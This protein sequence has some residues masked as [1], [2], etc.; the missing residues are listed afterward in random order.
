M[1]KRTQRRSVPSGIAFLLVLLLALPAVAYKLPDTGQTQC[2]GV[3]GKIKPI[4]CPPPD[5]PL[6]QDGSYTHNPLNY[7]YMPTGDALDVNTNLVWERMVNRPKES[8]RDAHRYCDNYTWG[9]FRNWRL[10]TVRELMGIVHYGVASPFIETSTFF[11]IPNGPYWTST[12]VPC[13]SGEWWT[14]DFS[15]GTPSFSN[16]PDGAYTLCVHGPELPFAHF[17]DNGNGTVT[18]LSTNLMWLKNEK[19][20]LPWA[21]ALKYCEGLV[22][23]GFADWRV[24]NIREYESLTKGYKGP[25][26]MSDYLN[27]NV[28]FPSWS[29]TTYVATNNDYSYK[30]TMDHLGNLGITSIKDKNAG[31][32]GVRCVRSI[33]RA[34]PLDEQEISAV[35]SELEFWHVNGTGVVQQK[36]DI[37]NAGGSRLIIDSV[38]HPSRPFSLAHDTC[39]GKPLGLPDSCI[40]AIAFDPSS[41]GTFSGTVQ[42]LSND[43]DNPSVS[44]RLKGTSLDRFYLP[45]TG[46]RNCYTENGTTIACPP[47][48]SPLTQDGSY[49]MNEP[50]YSVRENGTVRDDNTSLEWQRTDDGTLRTWDEA[51]TYCD[52]L[53][54]GTFTDWRVPKLKELAS[55]T[56]Y[57]RSNPSIE[58]GTFPETKAS[59]YWTASSSSSFD[60]NPWIVSFADGS[61]GR[62][63]KSSLH[64]VRC[65]RGAPLPQATLV[66]ESE[67]T[68]T[69][70]LTGIMW[71]RDDA[72]VQ[73]WA[74]ALGYCENL[75][76]AGYTDWRLP[77][78][79][80]LA[81]ILDTRY[82]PAIDNTMFPRV[83]CGYWSAYWSSTSSPASTD[84]AYVVDFYDATSGGL[85]EHKNYNNYHV[86]C[87]RGGFAKRPATITGTVIDTSSWLPLEGVTVTVTNAL[88]TYTAVTAPDGTF[89]IGGVTAG[90]FTATFTKAGYSERVVNWTVL[91]GETANL[92]VFIH[93]Q[94]PLL[95]SITSPI[96]GST[97]YTPSI[98]V[99]GTVSHPAFILVNNKL[100]TISDGVFSATIQLTKGV[101][102]ITV[103]ASDDYG[104]TAEDRVTITYLT[105]GTMRGVVTD[106]ANLRPLFA[107]NVTVTDGL[108]TV[109]AVST[110]ADGSYLIEGIEAGPFQGMVTKEGFEPYSFS[111]TLNSGETRIVNVPLRKTF[112]VTTL[113]DYGSVTVME[114]AGYYDAR[115]ADGSLNIAPRQEIAK[116]FFQLHPDAFDFL[117][118]FSNFTYAMPDPAAKGFYLEVKNDVSG[119]GKPLFDNSGSFGS[120]GK[121]QGTIDM[122]NVVTRVTDPRDPMFQDTVNT[123][124]HE[125]LHRWGAQVRFRDERGAI[126]T[127]L[128]G[129]D[130]SHWSYLLDS[131]ASLHYGNEWH[132]NGDGTFTSVGAEKYFSPLDLYLMGLYNRN[133]VPA[134][135]LIENPSLNPSA[136]PSPGTAISGSSRFVSIDDIIAAEGE[137]LPHFLSSQK[138]F[139]IA[140]ILITEP[141]TFTGAEIEGIEHVRTASAGTFSALTDGRGSITGVSPT[142]HVFISEPR[143]GDSVQQTVTVK[144]TFINSTGSDTGITVNGIPAMVYGNHFVANDVPLAEGLNTIT[145]TATDIEGM[146]A[147]ASV[148]VSVVPTTHSVQLYTD[149]EAGVVPF[150][151]SIR[152]ESSLSLTELDLTATG[153]VQPILLDRDGEEYRFMIPVEGHYTFAAEAEG[154]DGNRYRDALT[155]T[156][157]NATQMDKHLKRKWDGM[158]H[159]LMAQN[160][161]EALRYVSGETKAHYFDLFTALGASMPVIAADMPPIERM[162]IDGNSAKY[163]IRQMEIHGGQNI[164]ITHSIYFTIDN[165]GL[166]KIDWF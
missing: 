143:H 17:I 56:L 128:I 70:S 6:A 127:D 43:A 21:D 160:F 99:S 115:N 37:M 38:T 139:A 102:T 89:S 104:Q 65:V 122:G 154:F 44:I 86:F 25:S 116:E 64:Y 78:I 142:L 101:Q 147:S 124:L 7:W 121:L 123:L 157:W 92:D 131:G 94:P 11:S 88:T 48:G 4:P 29:S 54:L 46:Q 34:E 27:F 126:R 87:V 24:P 50:S 140:F 57:D 14:V 132:D 134:M 77:N 80:E 39:T 93:P 164:P 108:N 10:P 8:W 165:D 95:L 74:A 136:L 31:K 47:P 68:V 61:L 129:K 149:T 67:S 107:A 26:V 3:K 130:G 141:D 32:Y 118:I 137:R 45:D 103:F 33:A 90:Q 72:T 58:T 158:K 125:M 41:L 144:G 52:N 40:I 79:R 84:D 16:P 35:P 97:V 81:T 162:G 151:I 109:H 71:Q 19:T 159:A 60:E 85:F 22:Y 42:I 110:A 148:S 83:D 75:S 146:S 96:D 23:A 20:A 76:L 13:N 111:G 145:A 106:S 117:V 28:S 18:D 152:V 113:A 15:T 100:A 91:D 163:R 63:K 12:P 1:I 2:Y 161:E 69:D 55:I 66:L 62:A 98:T 120:A 150:A 5:D 153:P 53:E 133:E 166:W 49:V 138:A 82:K 105:Q 9:F 30:W 73:S 51:V 156:A 135:A 112:S 114:V 36:F 155:V 59:P 119:I